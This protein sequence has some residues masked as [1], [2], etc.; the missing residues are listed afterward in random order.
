MSLFY[1][2]EPLIDSARD[3]KMQFLA[4]AFEQ[5]FICRVP[6]ECVLELVGRIGRDA[7]NV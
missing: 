4:A 7:A 2:W 5:R 6:D 1:R 3:D